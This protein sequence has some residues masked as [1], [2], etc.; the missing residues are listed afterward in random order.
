MSCFRIGLSG[1]GGGLESVSSRELLELAELAERLGFDALWI[2]E[3]H[4][5]GSFIEIEGRR[6]LSP[7]TLASAMLARTSHIRVGFSVLLLPLHHPI[8]LAEEI[9]TLDVLSEGRV[10]FGISRGGNKRYLHV[11][12]VPEDNLDQK[13]HSCLDS[14]L[15]A[16]QDE[17]M[18]FGGAT[19]SV[20]PKPVQRPHPPI[21]VGTN[22]TPTVEWTARSGHTLMCHGIS[23]AVNSA[24]LVREFAAAGG[25][26]SRVPFGRFVYVSDSDASAREELWPVV[27]NLTRRLKTIAA[28]GAGGFLSEAD[29]EPEAFYR[30]MVIAG[31][32]DTCA[33]KIHMLR[34]Q[35]GI[36]YL[37]ALSAFFG[38]LPLALLRRSLHLLA[39]EVRPRVTDAERTPSP[40]N[41]DRPAATSSPR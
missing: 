12:G 8:R 26:V 22:T 17:P 33:A 2:N 13:F 15:R 20:E 36:N 41:V 30:H 29:L 39:R 5:Q 14:I 4:F 40:A 3:E 25:D 34:E 10:D 32:P 11:Y 27:L 24:R 21:F 19:Q 38:F 1:C 16:W 9:A 6:C 35:L 23:S 18:D 28:R 31:G 7:V 37:N